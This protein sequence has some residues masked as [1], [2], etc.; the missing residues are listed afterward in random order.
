MP[1]ACGSTSISF[2]V[3]AVT[4]FASESGSKGMREG[5]VATGGTGESIGGGLTSG[6]AIGGC[7]E[8]SSGGFISGMGGILGDSGGLMGGTL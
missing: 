7:P 4:P 5:A 1:P 3:L 8:P 2:R 6:I